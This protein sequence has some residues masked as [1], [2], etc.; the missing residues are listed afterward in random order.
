MKHFTELLAKQENISVCDT[1]VRNM[2]YEENILSPKAKWKTKNNPKK[3]REESSAIKEKRDLDTALECPERQDAHPRRPRCAN[4][5]ELI[6]MDASPHVWFGDVLT[7]LHLAVDDA[8]EKIVGA[9]FD[10]Q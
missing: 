5:D 6:Q 2:L 9:Y 4:F 7:H 1:T 8:T 3:A 10:D